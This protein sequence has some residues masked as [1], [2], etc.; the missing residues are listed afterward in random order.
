[1]TFDWPTAVLR[2]QT[3][4]RKRHPARVRNECIKISR[5]ELIAEELDTIIAETESRA[6]EPEQTLSETLQHLRAMGLVK[7]VGRGIYEFDLR[8]LINGTWHKAVRKGGG[9][10]WP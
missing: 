5:Q 4:I 1:M 10:D 7:F 9:W 2:A 3:R 6:D 8:P